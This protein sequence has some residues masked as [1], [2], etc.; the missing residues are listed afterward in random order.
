MPERLGSEVLPASQLKLDLYEFFHAEQI[1][2]EMPPRSH[3]GLVAPLGNEAFTARE[4][5]TEARSW[6]S[7][8]SQ[9]GH[10]HLLTP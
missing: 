10:K 2:V 3:A 8:A 6:W 4:T 5:A 9:R 1:F 7:L